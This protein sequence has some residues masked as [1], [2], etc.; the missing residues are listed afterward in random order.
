MSRQ[1]EILNRT[2]EAVNKN[3]AITVS[4]SNREKIIIKNMMEQYAKDC[5]KASLEKASENANLKVTTSKGERY[6]S[7]RNDTTQGLWGT[8]DELTT[9]NKKSITNQENIVLL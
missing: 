9:V 5:C 2:L 3:N 1:S 4:F 6:Y 8:Y 7:A